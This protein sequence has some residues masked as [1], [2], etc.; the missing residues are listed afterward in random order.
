MSR[1]LDAIH[2]I[3]RHRVAH[4]ATTSG[5]I[6]H[7]VPVVFVAVE[8]SIW[9]PIDGKPKATDRLKRVRNIEANPRVALLVDVYDEDW[10]ALEWCRID[11]TASIAA[12]PPGVARSLT[13][14]YPQY[15]SVDVGATAIRIEP[16]GAASWAMG[17]T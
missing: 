2:A 4:L 9:I 17:R 13:E 11:G 12:T 10:A 7:L 1:P 15:R 8:G 14:K 6:P 3:D 5:D 16:I